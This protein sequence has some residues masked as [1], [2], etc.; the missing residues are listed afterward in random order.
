VARQVCSSRGDRLVLVLK[1]G[2]H[3]RWNHR[4]GNDP[5]DRCECGDSHARGSRT[6]LPSPAP[7]SPL[8][9]RPLVLGLVVAAAPL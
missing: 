4:R 3:D 1:R 5:G 6:A 2:R 9:A 8:A 7:P